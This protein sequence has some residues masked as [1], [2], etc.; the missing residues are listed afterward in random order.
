MDN[1]NH[2]APQVDL[3]SGTSIEVEQESVHRAGQ[4]LPFRARPDDFEGYFGQEHVF[5]RYSFLKSKNFPSLVI[6]G[7]PGTGKTTLAHILAKN[8]GLELYNFNAVLG[9]VNDLKKLIASA[10]SMKER[11]N[12]EAIIF[13]DEIHR[14][15]KAQQDALLPYVEQGSFILIGAT[16]ENPRSSVNRAL[17]S[18]VQIIELKKL[19]EENLESIIRNVAKRFEINID[20]DCV[21]FISDYSNGDARNSLNILELLE[22]NS[23]GDQKL[24]TLSDVKPMVLEN[25]REYDRNKDRHYDVISAFIKS[26][27]GSD[28]SA[29]LLWLAVM[30]DGGEDPVFI[31]R[32][33]V[34]FASED[35]G[36]ADPQA[37]T[38][39]TSCLTAVAQIGMPEARINLAQATTYLAATVKS[40]AAYLGINEAL[41]YVESNQTIEVPHHLKN[42]P[43][44]DATVTYQYPHSFP[45]HYVKQDYTPA[46]TPEFYRPTEMGL[47]KNIKERLSKLK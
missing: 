36:N 6:W 22:K 25:A 19:S 24:L 41:S 35:V 30:L 18:R 27:R 1:N 8:S 37:L 44:K 33:L 38:M 7:P 34:V 3:F 26:M 28:P 47:E 31:A 20:E 9:G 29:A 13:I 12:Q 15:N 45:H 46:G 21:H 5:K 10:I 32:R 14:F 17:L 42:Y 11:Y 16:T 43:P 4:P 39:A 40:N 2:D 23:A